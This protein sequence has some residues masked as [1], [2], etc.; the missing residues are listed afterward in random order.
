VKL[1]DSSGRALLALLSVAF[2]AAVP[3]AAVTSK[4][5]NESERPIIVLLVAALAAA[6]VGLFVIDT[7]RQRKHPL[8]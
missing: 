2:V 4:V 5:Q 1:L 3:W 8:R 6:L 7:R